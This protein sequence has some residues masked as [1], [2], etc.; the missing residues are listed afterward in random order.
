MERTGG[1]RYSFAIRTPEHEVIR[2]DSRREA[3]EAKLLILQF[4]RRSELQYSE[5]GDTL[6]DSSAAILV[7]LFFFLSAFATVGMVTLADAK[8]KIDAAI[9]RGAFDEIWRVVEDVR[10]AVPV[11]PLADEIAMEG[12]QAL[13]KQPFV[14]PGVIARDRGGSPLLPRH[15]RGIAV[16]SLSDA[17]FF[18]RQLVSMFDKLPIDVLC[19][20]LCKL[21]LV[22]PA[23]RIRYSS[24]RDHVPQVFTE[25]SF[26]AAISTLCGSTQGL[27]I[28]AT[29]A[30]DGFR[31][32]QI[33]LIT[34]KYPSDQAPFVERFQREILATFS[35]RQL[36]DAPLSLY[37]GDEDDTSAVRKT[38]SL[39]EFWMSLR[40]KG[41]PKGWTHV[42]RSKSS[43][44]RR[45]KMWQHYIAIDRA[46]LRYC[47]KLCKGSL[48]RMHEDVLS[49][50]EGYLYG[51][52]SWPTFFFRDT[53]SRTRTANVHKSSATAAE[54]NKCCV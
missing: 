5:E 25:E 31:L 46:I 53:Y 3:S 18:F 47:F 9:A 7:F 19:C 1:L 6:L 23:C 22:I 13:M 45:Y 27:T 11:N 39:A 54:V 15:R 43:W 42:D 51:G 14:K 24:H 2:S 48:G 52:H 36:F 35:I 30:I 8:S 26:K 4:L 44:F 12:C 38:M 21:L 50:V 49:D 37:V 28:F 41:S 16:R 33:I 34:D 29:E 40:P 32:L 10:Y 20:G 17:G